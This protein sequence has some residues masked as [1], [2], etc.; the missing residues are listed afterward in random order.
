MTVC[1]YLNLREGTRGDIEECREIGGITD[2]SYIYETG[3][4]GPADQPG[5]GSTGR[6][7]V[8]PPPRNPIGYRQAGRLGRLGEWRRDES[9]RGSERAPAHRA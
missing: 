2:Q 1:K 9:E 3:F 5:Y 6:P 7:A 4:Q 8:P